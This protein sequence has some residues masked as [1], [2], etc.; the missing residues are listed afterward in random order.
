MG[1]G[2]LF[3]FSLGFGKV[4]SMKKFL[5]I[6]LILI[7]FALGAGTGY[8]IAPKKNSGNILSETAKDKRIVFVLEVYDLIKENYWNIISDDESTN[9]FALGI[10]KLTGQV[11]NFK[12]SDKENLEKALTSFISQIDSEEKKKEFAVTLADVV[13]SNLPPFGRSRLYT[14]KEEKELAQ[15]VKNINPETNEV[16]PT[17]ESKIIR[18][19]IFYLQIKKFSPMTFEELKKVTEEVD[20][21]KALGNLILDLRGNIGG[22]LD[23]LSYFLGPFIGNNQYA[24]QFFHQGETTDFKTKTGW[25]PSLV[26]YKKV[27]VLI[28]GETQSSAEVFAA[29]LKKYNVGVLIGTPTK[30]WGTVERVFP[31]ENQFD[32][33]EKYSVFLVHSLTLRD[34]GQPIEGNGVEPVVNINDPN[35]QEQLYGYFHYD[36]LIEVVK[37]LLGR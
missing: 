8:V 37:E 22:D 24:Y 21:Q 31:L 16:E 32:E 3:T 28:D 11:Q 25:L 13:L 34:D 7:V 33:Q 6:S 12:K 1:F 15:N 17:I 29:A 10:E 2:N 4:K 19:E 35:W 36:E 18:P 27:V 5:V 26:R 14:Q 23:G 20:D 30:G 9:L